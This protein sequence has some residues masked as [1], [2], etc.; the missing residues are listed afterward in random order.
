VQEENP[1]IIAIDDPAVLARRA[2]VLGGQGVVGAPVDEVAAAEQ[3]KFMTPAQRQQELF[4][5]AREMELVFVQKAG[6]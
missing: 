6:L 2:E 4:R 3:P 5:L 1:A